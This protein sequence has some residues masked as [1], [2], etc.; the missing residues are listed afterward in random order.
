MN[1]EAETIQVL[2]ALAAIASANHPLTFIE[3]NYSIEACEAASAISGCDATF[4]K[5]LNKKFREDA[6]WMM[7][8]R[9]A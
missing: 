6:A 1:I 8:E 9:A 2:T 3:T 4:C 7:M 5:M